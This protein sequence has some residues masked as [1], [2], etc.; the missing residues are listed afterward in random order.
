MAL[1]SPIVATNA[2]GTAEIVRHGIDALIVPF[3][4]EPA[5]TAALLDAVRH[6]DATAARVRAARERVD[7]GSLNGPDGIAV[8][9]FR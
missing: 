8:K 4:D 1:E 7:T 9:V 3:R 6:R 5:L 2:G